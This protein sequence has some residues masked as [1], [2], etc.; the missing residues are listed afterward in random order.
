MSKIVMIV[1]L[2][3]AFIF[4]IVMGGGLFIMWSK[5][6]SLDRTLNPQ[7]EKAS[8]EMGEESEMILRTYSL[9]TF[10]VNLADEGAK[11]YLR[12]TMKFEMSNDEMDKEIKKRLP[13]IQDKIL[14]IL[15]TKKVEEL[16]KMEGKIALRNEIIADLNSILTMGEITNVFFTEFVIQ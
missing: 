3:V 10:I 1:I 12:V 6:S 4:M 7:E 13:Q 11:R 2:I 8:E 9:D 5:I 16:Q 15:P 14:M